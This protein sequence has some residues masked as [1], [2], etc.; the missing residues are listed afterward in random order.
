LS[1]FFDKK[2][3]GTAPQ[4]SYKTPSSNS[5]KIQRG[6]AR[7]LSRKSPMKQTSGS[8]ERSRHARPENRPRPSHDQ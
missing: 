3:G 7:P 1:R 2:K 8:A 4:I 6:A 5:M